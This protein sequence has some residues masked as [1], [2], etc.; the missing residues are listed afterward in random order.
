VMQAPT[1]DEW[2]DVLAGF[3]SHFKHPVSADQRQRAR[4][5]AGDEPTARKVG[6]R[7]K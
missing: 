2:N 5:R 3:S 7:R 6:R 1:R 4:G